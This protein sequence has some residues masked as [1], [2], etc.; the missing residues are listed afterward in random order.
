[1]IRLHEAAIG[2]DEIDSL[3]HMNMRYYGT[4]A[5]AATQALFASWG[6][7]EARLA[8]EGLVL[9]AADCFN[10]YLK[11]QFDGA[12]LI[13]DGGVCDVRADG[14]SLY[15]E[16]VN[17]ANGDKAAT[18]ITR[19][20]LMDR[21]TRTAQHYP[22]AL[23]DKAEGAI[24]DVPPYGMPR[25]L[26][27]SPPRTDAGYGDI[28]S[29]LGP[30]SHPMFSSRGEIRVPAEECDEQGFL[31]LTCA[32]D[33]MFSAFAAAARAAG[34]RMG[35]PIEAGPDG[36]RIGW[37]M[38]ENRQFLVQTPRAGDPI[39]TLSAPT[40]LG[41]K[42]QHMRRWTFNTDTGALLSVIDGVSLA[43]DLDARRAIEIP[44]HMRA[45]L[46]A[47]LLDELV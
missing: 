27:L 7:D 33:I 6:W 3:G 39:T 17:V 14:L 24:V 1:M 28:K 46:E 4:R 5:A 23:L 44:P 21:K 30:I 16:L 13:V 45:E 18:F 43:L 11:E 32:Q 9:V 31:N 41:A 35:P 34:M 19:P 42:T 37:A 40:K 36:R 22:K 10:H 29:R 25:S 8:K 26:D 20:V 12:T 15:L 2:P 47:S 38:L